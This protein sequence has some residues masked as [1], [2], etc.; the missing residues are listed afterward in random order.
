MSGQVMNEIEDHVPALRRHAYR[1][2]GSQDRANDLVQD[3]LL[4]AIS[5][6]DK[7]EEGTSLKAWLH[8]ILFNTFISEVRRTKTRGHHVDWDDLGDVYGHGSNQIA[9]LQLRD[10]D[11][12]LDELPEQ[13]RQAILLTTVEEMSYQDAAEFMNVEIGTVKSRVGRARRKLRGMV[14]QIET[15]EHVSRFVSE[16]S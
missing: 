11:R 5:K 10:A 1:L 3:T 16:A 9:R 6:Q 4:K 12:V 15:R 14:G 13:E 2:T 7:F 8:R